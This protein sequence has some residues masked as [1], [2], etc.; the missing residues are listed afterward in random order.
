MRQPLFP[1][2][3]KSS[4]VELFG[5]DPLEHLNI[6]PWVIIVLSNRGGDDLLR[7]NKSAY[8]CCMGLFSRE[9]SKNRIPVV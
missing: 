3:K 7:L 5:V 6:F 2:E 4:I 9:N 8:S 1:V